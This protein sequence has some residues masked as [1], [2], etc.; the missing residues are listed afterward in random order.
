MCISR[1]IRSGVSPYVILFFRLLYYWRFLSSSVL[2]AC[3]VLLN[4]VTVV[5]V[6]CGWISLTPPIR[7][8][9][10]SFRTLQVAADLKL[11][12]C[13]L[14]FL[15]CFYWPVKCQMLYLR[16]VGMSGLFT[17]SFMLDSQ[18]TLSLITLVTIL[19]IIIS[20]FYREIIEARD[21]KSIIWLS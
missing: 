2:K 6:I 14:A 4:A 3:M 21:G 16:W 18:S 10:W 12:P 20:F 11:Q 8:L 1:C 5:P 17:T 15:C 19:S 13:T 7:N 9:W